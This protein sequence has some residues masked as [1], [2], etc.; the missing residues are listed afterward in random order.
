MKHLTLD[1]HLNLCAVDFSGKGGKENEI[2]A[3]LFHERSHKALVDAVD[4]ASGILYEYKK[5]SGTQWFDLSKLAKL[6]KKQKS[7]DVLFFI[8]KGGVFQAAYS[9]TYQGVIDAIGLS[10]KDWAWAKKAPETAQVKYALKRKQ[11]ETFHCL[12]PATRKES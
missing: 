3:A 6:T 1:Q 7:I 10:K 9:T 4:P 12:T 2:A 5:Q 8:H 11:I